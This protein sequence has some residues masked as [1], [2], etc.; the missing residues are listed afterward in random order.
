M[1]IWFSRWHKEVM[2]NTQLCLT[3]ESKRW[4]GQYFSKKVL[5]LNL[6]DIFEI[7]LY[8]CHWF[9]QQYNNIIASS[10]FQWKIILFLYEYYEY[11]LRSVY[12]KFSRLK[13]LFGRL[14]SV[15][16]SYRVWFTAFTCAWAVQ[17]LTSCYANLRF[18]IRRFNHQLNFPSHHT[19]DTPDT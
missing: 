4:K 2:F 1:W 3:V 5:L 9:S 14:L 18:P 17:G 10:W 16:K 12:Q 6:S 19:S 11:G 8:F 15:L 7:K 13:L